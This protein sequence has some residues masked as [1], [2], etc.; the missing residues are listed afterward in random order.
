MVVDIDITHTVDMYE[1]DGAKDTKLLFFTFKC[2]VN[3]ILYKLVL[4]YFFVHDKIID[5]VFFFSS[6]REKEEVLRKFRTNMHFLL[7]CFVEVESLRD[8]TT[9]HSIV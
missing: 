5:S 1:L 8:N 7:A 2:E 6:H 9:S 3:M 4:V